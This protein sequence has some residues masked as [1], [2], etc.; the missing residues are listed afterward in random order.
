MQNT[1]HAVHMLP[2]FKQ[3]VAE[4]IADSRAQ[5]ERLIALHDKLYEWHD[6]KIENLMYI[7][8]TQLEN[9]GLFREQVKRWQLQSL[10]HE[11]QYTV[12]Q[13]QMQ[14]EEC[15]KITYDVMEWV[16]H[17]RPD[18]THCLYKTANT[19]RGVV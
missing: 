18:L 8:R 2:L 9:M 16:T 13:F 19:E 15:E 14:L 4:I 17:Q 10:T 12:E 5:Y 3:H 7:Y 11:E 6:K 1:N